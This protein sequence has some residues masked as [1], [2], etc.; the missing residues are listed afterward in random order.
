[1]KKNASTKRVI[2]TQS[3]SKPDAYSLPCA[4]HEMYLLQIICRAFDTLPMMI[5]PYSE[6]LRSRRC[7]YGCYT[8]E[9]MLKLIKNP[10]EFHAEL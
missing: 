9:F 1:M 3:V 6:K 10:A 8:K 7:F 5:N 4:K 2:L